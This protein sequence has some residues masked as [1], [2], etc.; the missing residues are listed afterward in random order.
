MRQTREVLN[1]IEKDLN[2]LPP[3]HHFCYHRWICNSGKQQSTRVK[4]GEVGADGNNNMSTV[5]G[6]SNL[7][8]DQTER[9]R[10]ERSELLSQILFVYAK[11]HPALGYRQGMH[12]I[13]SYIFL[14][15]ETDLL[16]HGVKAENVSLAGLNDVGEDKESDETKEEDVRILD[17]AKIMHDAFILFECVMSSLAPAYDAQIIQ[18]AEQ[19]DY[20]SESP[21]EVMSRSI[22]S[23]IRHVAG[24]EELYRHITNMNVPPQLYCTR[25]VRLM[26]SREVVGQDNV[27][28]L[29][30]LFFDLT[31]TS[32]QSQV[33]GAASASSTLL[34]N[35]L[36]STAASMILLIR[37]KILPDA[38]TGDH[39]DNYEYD[40]N[41]CINTLMNYPPLEDV[42][43][44]I[45]LIMSMVLQQ[46]HYFQENLKKRKEKA[47]READTRQMPRPGAV[48]MATP[49][50]PAVASHVRPV[51]PL[52]RMIS[53]RG[54]LRFGSLSGG[55]LQQDWPSS[56]SGTPQW[57]QGAIGS[58]GRI[59]DKV[60]TG[61]A[62]LLE[63]V[64]EHIG[65]EEKHTQGQT[66]EHYSSSSKDLP[67]SQ[68]SSASTE[69][70]KNTLVITNAGHKTSTQINSV[71]TVGKK[72]ATSVV[73]KGHDSARLEKNAG[74]DGT[75]SNLSDLSKFNRSGESISCAHLAATIDTHLS[76][77]V[78]H[79]RNTIDP[80]GENASENK[81][82][83]SVDNIDEKT[84][85]VDNK[86][87]PPNV[88]ESVWEAIIGIDMV[89]VELLKK[90]K[91]ATANNSFNSG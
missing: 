61:S 8:N 40:P 24:D 86:S 90:E 71:I 51:A 79:F 67:L 91:S 5:N 30:D 49:N 28:K 57:L 59:A 76:I 46:Q 62:A 82:P 78:D 41:D 42:T 6:A 83:G 29:W 26:F 9:S 56:T 1:V 75:I 85:R 23:K 74:A 21:M 37:D 27:M 70:V 20:Q 17:A 31:T 81:L 80:E 72:Q 84:H 63:N 54:S 89:R 65:S 35:V 11:E 52:Q 64:G 73:T 50:V 36:E 58:V 33:K 22:V 69:K 66:V 55:D 7:S 3:D 14:A 25:W 32:S 34:M 39:E 13:L 53:R 68:E 60:V 44:L 47:R 45:D 12:E 19:R 88:P 4:S 77:L 10:E 18:S 15:I 43:Q 2:R 38:T 87:P 48:P 16:E